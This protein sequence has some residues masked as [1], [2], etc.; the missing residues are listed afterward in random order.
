MN[1]IEA[2]AEQAL[3]GISSP[4]KEIVVVSGS[5]GLIGSALIRKLAGKYQVI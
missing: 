5:S 2:T 1:R 3:T 4:K